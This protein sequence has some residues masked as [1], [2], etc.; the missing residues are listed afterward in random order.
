MATYDENTPDIVELM[1]ERR[2]RAGQH[3]ANWRK[4]ARECYEFR[5]GDQW[6]GGDRAV[7]EEAGRPVVTFNRT[8]P[9]IDSVAGYEINNR[10]E[11]RFFPRTINDRQV[12]DTF[13][14]AAR[15]VRDMCDAEDEESDVY[16][17]ALTTGMGWAR[18]RVDYT[19]DMDGKIVEERVPVLNVFW[20]DKAR[21]HNVLDANWLVYQEWW[22]V[23]DVHDEWPD[24]GPVEP[25]SNFLGDDDWA[26]E[27]DATNAWKYEQD[28][29][30]IY[31]PHENRILVFH[32]QWREKE[33]FYRVEDPMTGEIVE[34]DK[35]RYDKVFP[36]GPG[37]GIQA[38]QQRKWVYYH[39]WIAG[40][41]LLD[42]GKAPIDGFSYRCVTGKRDEQ[43]N[44]FYGLV[45]AMRDP[46]QWANKFFSQIMHIFNTNSKGGVLLEESAVD[47]IRQFEDAWSD[48]S[49]VIQV[50]DGAITGGKIME[51]SMGGYPSALDKMLSFAISSIRDVSGVNLELMGM[52]NRE[53]P[54]ILEVERKKAALVILS[55]ILNNLRRFRKTQSLDLLQFMRKY[56]Q[57][58]T[59][60]RIT[61]Q[62][63]TQF[64]Y[65]P[66]VVKYDV[67]IDTAPTSP[68]LKSDVWQNMQNIL[69]AMMKAG[70]PI[71]PDILKFSPLPESV[72]DEWINYIQ[73][74]TQQ[75]PELP[76]KF[77]QLQQEMGQLQQENQQLQMKREQAMA[78]LELKRVE[79]A[80]NM[81][82]EQ[83]RMLL[84]NQIA[85]R[86]LIMKS[87]QSDADRAAK[88]LELQSSYDIKKTELETKCKMERERADTQINAQRESQ[89]FELEHERARLVADTTNNTDKV[90]E[91]IT[92]EIAGAIVG[93]INEAVTE[94][95]SRIVRIENEVSKVADVAGKVVN[96][97]DKIAEADQ[98]RSKVLGF[99]SKE[100]GDLAEL[101]EELK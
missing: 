97:E 90:A 85:E 40:K 22:N 82:M 1:H 5:D 35:E 64:M 42:D 91:Q 88:L 63:V 34:F 13:T 93:Q 89:A 81:R 10:H 44:T 43:T 50:N 62:D 15:W 57:P 66:D 80:E 31:D 56:L 75:D 2:T 51:K 38:I 79:H 84:E 71:P 96:I 67:I 60:M 69:P 8:G 45:R 52:A 32:Y 78:Q 61:D 94:V 21:K 17:D 25:S 23:D 24:A 4:E 26:D 46:Q 59:L 3:S 27:H 41:T 74:K 54:G 11:A 101:A 95:A 29:N 20:D 65:D 6:D 28:H 16:I 77:Q 48:P 18:T 83:E 12:N 70:A 36:D 37:E 58:G 86:E 14:E 87:K 19:E 53:Q 99:V 68:N 33:V 92:G 73:Q 98:R 76:Q 30:W 55:P 9:I 7:L 39:A 49:G 72:S 100:G 47:D